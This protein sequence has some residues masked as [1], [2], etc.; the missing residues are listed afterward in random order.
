MAIKR[1]SSGGFTL[2]E[3]LVVIAIIA[4]LIGLLIP[5]VQNAREA[6]AR[7]AGKSS[8]SDVLCPPP[9]CNGLDANFQRITLFYPTDLTGLTAES[10]LAPGLHVTDSQN[11]L[12]GHPF[13]VYRWA[14]DSL[15][16]PF[17]V[18]FAL[19]ADVVDGNDYALL[20]VS[21]T[22]PG[23]EYLVRQ[24]TDGDLW[25]LSASVDAS[26][27]SVAFSA[28]AAQVPEPAT[29]LL[30]LA[31]LAPFAWTHQ[32]RRGHGRSGR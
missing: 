26:T 30:L 28:A 4:V 23:V 1:A 10:A 14:E 3:L 20:D 8:I 32:R 22:D 7:Q 25:K 12:G 2:I 24:G 17:D 16:D 29:L 27:R 11:Y 13:S 5:A 9:F 18:L 31:A 15:V 6:A 19:G 21:Y